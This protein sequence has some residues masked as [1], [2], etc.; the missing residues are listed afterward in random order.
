MLSDMVARESPRNKELPYL[1]TTLLPLHG[2]QTPRSE[3]QEVI[4]ANVL[5][6]SLA[7]TAIVAAIEANVDTV[8]ALNSVFDTSILGCSSISSEI[9]QHSI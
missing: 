1:G 9:V 6:A 7:C 8:L 5:S 3:D 4:C 2:E